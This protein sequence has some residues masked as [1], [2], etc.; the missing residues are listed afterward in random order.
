MRNSERLLSREKAARAQQVRTEI[1]RLLRHHYEASSPPM[2]DRLLELI[3][4]FELQT[5]AT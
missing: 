2:S 3:K 1:G 4:K 5:V